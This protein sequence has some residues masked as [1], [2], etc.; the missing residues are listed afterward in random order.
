MTLDTLIV[1]WCYEK[2]L[3]N[4]NGEKE[5]AFWV[6]FLQFFPKKELSIEHVKNA[7]PPER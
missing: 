7:D 1:F 6:G 4:V 2:S 5:Q 3:L